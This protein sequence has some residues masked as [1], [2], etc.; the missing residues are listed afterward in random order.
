MSGTMQG[1]GDHQKNKVNHQKKENVNNSGQIVN[2][3][4]KN[5]KH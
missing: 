4:S 5:A 2:N 3:F 1:K